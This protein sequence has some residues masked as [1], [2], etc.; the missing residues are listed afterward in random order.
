M[1]ENGPAGLVAYRW[2]SSYWQPLG[3]STPISLQTHVRDPD[4]DHF[5]LGVYGQKGTEGG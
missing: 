5:S 2:Q 1:P 3:S 4:S